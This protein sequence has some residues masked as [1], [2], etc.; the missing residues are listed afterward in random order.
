MPKRMTVNEFNRFVDLPE[1]SDKTF[2][3]V[4]GEAIEVPSSPYNSELASNILFFL[5]GF[6]RLH[7]M[8]HLTGEKAGYTVSGERYVPNVAYISEQ[9][10]TEL[11]RLGYVESAPE[12]VVEIVSPGDSMH[13][14][15][16]KIANY[17]V[18]GTLVWLVLPETKEVEIYAPGQ[19]ARII[20]VESVLDGGDVLPEFTL[21]VKDIFSA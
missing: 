20:G 8:G 14:I 7:H 9:R 6:V 17:L 16:T 3:Y 1:H 15:R 5:G 21:A 2:E 19:P 10:Q 11:P 13:H 12:L 18:A 4:G